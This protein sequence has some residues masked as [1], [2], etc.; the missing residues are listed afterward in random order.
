MKYVILCL[1]LVSSAAFADAA[2]QANEK[3][4]AANDQPPGTPATDNSSP[5]TAQGNVLPN[6]SHHAAVAPSEFLSAPQYQPQPL[7]QN[8]PSPLYSLSSH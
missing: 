6:T 2:V 4:K 5:K 8:G 1:V 7:P 3:Q